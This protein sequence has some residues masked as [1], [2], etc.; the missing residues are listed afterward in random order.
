MD[1]RT[2]VK[3]AGLGTLATATAGC[4]SDVSGDTGQD[5]NQAQPSEV[6]IEDVEN[7]DVERTE[8]NTIEVEGTGVVE[9]DPDTATLSVSIEAH[10]RD[11]ADAVVEELAVRGD[12]LVED[13]TAFGIPED[14]ITTTRYS[15]RESSRRSRYEGHHRFGIEIDDPDSVGEVIDLVADSEADGIRSVDFTVSEEK[16]EELYDEAVQR[17]VDDAREEAALYTAA[18]GVSL[19]EPVSIETPQTGVSPFSRTFSLSV[20]EAA[21]DDAPSTELQQ[22]D[23]SVTAQVTIEYEFKADDQ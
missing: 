18:A 5:S 19:G 21:T 17:A 9:T 15:L 7:L 4:I 11:D 14:D 1:R 2:F 6:T 22:G 8:R 13:L 16:R 12:Q 23:V 20:A 3:L 10:D